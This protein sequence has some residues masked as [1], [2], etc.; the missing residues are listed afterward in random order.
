MRKMRAIIKVFGKRM[1]LRNDCKSWNNGGGGGGMDI[2]VKS[3]H[4]R[5]CPAVSMCRFVVLV[6]KIERIYRSFSFPLLGVSKCATNSCVA[7]LGCSPTTIFEL[8]LIV[9]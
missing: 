2:A 7:W 1:W 9:L 8:S 3:S 5:D 4:R 6:G